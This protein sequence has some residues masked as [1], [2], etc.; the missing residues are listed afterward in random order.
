MLLNYIYFPI[1]YG[2]DPNTNVKGTRPLH[3]ALDGAHIEA[4]VQLLRHG[5][6]PLLY[7][8]SGNMPIDLAKDSED[9][10]LL[11]YFSAILN[12]L[13]GKAGMR[14]NVAHDRGYVLPQSVELDLP[15]VA[16]L[17]VHDDDDF[18]FEASAQPLPPQFRFAQRLNEKYVL[19]N[20]LKRFTPMDVNKLANKFSV[21][22]MPREEFLKTA[23]SCLLGATVDPGKADP[24]V[25]VKVEPSL[26]KLMGVN[27]AKLFNSVSAHSPSKHRGKSS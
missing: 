13:H 7:D 3:E 23:F 12:D 26:H 22:K 18:D 8:Y 19:A 15:K 6:D 20:D 4:V 5:A 24:V 2:A 11:P 9:P 17:S 14:W 27:D 25:L 1:R 10:N 21:V 16:S